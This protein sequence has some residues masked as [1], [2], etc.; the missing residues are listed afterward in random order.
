MADIYEDQYWE[1]EFDITKND[2]DRIAKRIKKKR[3]AF[4]LTNLVN[5]IVIGRLKH[6][7]DTGP[8]VLPDW[9]KEQKVRSW[10]EIESWKVGERV[11]VA[12]STE[13]GNIKPYFGVIREATPT[14]FYVWLEEIDKNVRY[15]RVDKGSKRGRKYYENV[16]RAIWQRE[17][18]SKKRGKEPNVEEQ[19]ELIMLSHGSRIASRLLNALENDS[20]FVMYF[21]RWF[22]RQLLVPIEQS[23]IE[24][25]HRRMVINDRPHTLEE[26][27]NL[28]PINLPKGDE[29]LF[30]IYQTLCENEDL[31]E[32]DDGKWIAKTPPP[33][34]WQ[35]AKGLN[36][37]YDPET[38]RIIVQPEQQITKSVAERLQD[39]GWYE[40]VVTRR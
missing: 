34:P 14:L 16:T 9:V 10:D 15:E 38:F 11:L 23:K 13:R 3:I 12:R 25:I 29:G 22:L 28:T 7:R 27:I 1:N 2:L 37:V 26:I 5:R 17:K 21:D 31:F 4:S 8:A 39:L 24:Q 36:Y 6:G 33:L 30:S 35:Q 20:R 32:F 40:I 18:A 19:V